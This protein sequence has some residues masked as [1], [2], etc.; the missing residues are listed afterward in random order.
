MKEKAKKFAQSL[1]QIY[2]ND[3]SF[4]PLLHDTYECIK[5]GINYQLAMYIYNA[6]AKIFFFLFVIRLELELTLLL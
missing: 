3:S 4:E 2:E 5:V 6:D 1:I